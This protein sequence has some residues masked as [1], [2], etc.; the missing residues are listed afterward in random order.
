M[1]EKLKTFVK[2]KGCSQNTFLPSD[3]QIPLVGISGRDAF[4]YR[5]NEVTMFADVEK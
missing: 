4:K 2:K 5:E 1:L 3:S